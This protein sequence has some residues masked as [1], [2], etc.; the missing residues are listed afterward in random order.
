MQEITSIATAVKLVS[1]TGAGADHRDYIGDKSLQSYLKA[2]VTITS[3]PGEQS[4]MRKRATKA[5][6]FLCC[7]VVCCLLGFFV[8]L[9]E[10]QGQ[11]DKK[12]AVLSVKKL[13]LS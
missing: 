3:I 12:L 9:N 5:N 13:F 8:T 4:W 7:R 2:Q 10:S 1:N 6:T 11:T